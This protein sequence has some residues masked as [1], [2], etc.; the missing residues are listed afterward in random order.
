MTMHW[1]QVFLFKYKL[2]HNLHIQEIDRFDP[3]KTSARK[4]CSLS[5]SQDLLISV[6]DPALDT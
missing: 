5:E 3:R 1:A 2:L 4:C 6:L